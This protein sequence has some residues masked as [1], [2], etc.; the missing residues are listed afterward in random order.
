MEQAGWVYFGR[1]GKI[2]QRSGSWRPLDGSE[3]LAIQEGEQFPSINGKATVFEMVEERDADPQKNQPFAFSTYGVGVLINRLAQ[4][5]QIVALLLLEDRHKS[6][7]LR[8]GDETRRV[9]YPA[10]DVRGTNTEV[11]ADLHRWKEMFLLAVEGLGAPPSGSLESRSSASAED[12][13]L[14]AERLGKLEA[15]MTSF[16]WTGL[17]N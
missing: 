15:R 7:N 9:F 8:E 5:E 3:L 10:L 14:L 12:I 1:T 17:D 13:R 11:H 16:D 6:I 4:L 2:C